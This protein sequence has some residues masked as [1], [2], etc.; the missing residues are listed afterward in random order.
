MLIVK[1][2]P[3]IV[4]IFRPIQTVRKYLYQ[5]KYSIFEFGQP[6]LISLTIKT[7]LNTISIN[8]VQTNP[9]KNMNFPF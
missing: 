6:Y 7:E 4:L 5:Q 1:I 8:W 2:K 9:K 3:L